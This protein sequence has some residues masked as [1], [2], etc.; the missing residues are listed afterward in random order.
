MKDIR[1]IIRGLIKEELPMNSTATVDYIDEKWNALLKDA[2]HDIFNDVGISRINAKRTHEG[3]RIAID[4]NNGDRLVGATISNP[5]CGQI[6]IN[7]KFKKELNASQAMR[8]VSS[9]R[10]VWDEFSGT[11]DVK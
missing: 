5:M 10:E 1:E 7:G 4:L 6:I 2:L 9:M 8:L 11:N 3:S